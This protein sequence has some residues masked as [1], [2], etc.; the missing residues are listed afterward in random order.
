MIETRN[1]DGRLGIGCLPG[2]DDRKVEHSVHL[3]RASAVEEVGLGRE[4]P[5]YEP[6]VPQH[7]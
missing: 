1:G 5:G 4:K 7:S 3:L 6:N 2:P